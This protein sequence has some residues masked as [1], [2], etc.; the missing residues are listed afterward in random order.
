MCAL[1][2]F[3]EDLMAS[4]LGCRRCEK[5]C[6]SLKL[7][8]CSP[9]LSMLERENA[10]TELCIGCGKCSAVCKHTDPRLALMYLKAELVQAKVP[11]TFYQTGFI[12]L[13]ASDEWKTQVPEYREGDEVCLIP[14]CKV[15]S[16]VPFLKYATWKVFDSIGI[17]IG[18]LPGNT[19]CMY[20]VPF[21]V[22]EEPIR[23]GYKYKLRVNA[24]G[25]DM[26]T[27]CSGCTN[28]LGTSGIYAPHVS[29][30]L[31]KYLDRIRSFPGVSLKVALEPG[32]SGE[33][34]LTDT[35][36][37]VEATGAEIVNRT[38]G[39]CGKNIEGINDKLMAERELE[40][41]GADVIVVCCPNCMTF[42]DKY[43]GG[44]PVIHIVEL[45]A[46][47]A[48]DSNTLK[49]HNIRLSEDILAK[50]V[51]CDG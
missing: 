4:C 3:V 2:R 44:L 37:I 50:K 1:P 18:E 5:V 24:E 8:G 38:F 15:Q 28:E 23:N 43:E 22:M 45:L 41:R 12:M 7:G 20:P 17:G 31:T 51:K 13:P 39:C 11:D 49:F 33:R 48:G 26:V 10:N 27:L 32:C 34:F 21:R 42:Y 35:R 29:T 47:A 36:M 25:K 40:C 9:W 14:G 19:C 6:P 46:L 16:V 30:Y